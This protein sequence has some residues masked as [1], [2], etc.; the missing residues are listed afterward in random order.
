MP[1]LHVHTFIYFI[2]LLFCVWFTVSKNTFG[3]MHPILSGCAVKK[4]TQ[5]YLHHFCFCFKYTCI[6]S[7]L[8]TYSFKLQI[9]LLA[10]E[11]CVQRPR[12]C[13][14]VASDAQHCRQMCMRM[15]IVVKAGARQTGRDKRKTE[16]NKNT[17]LCPMHNTRLQ[18]IK[19]FFVVH[20]TIYSSVF[21]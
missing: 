1:T 15:E 12:F 19:V 21:M 4:P 18:Q 2:L 9:D 7:I 3:A 10:I 6:S 11:A 20:F 14:C 17:H 8:Q 13:S 16:Q 5:L